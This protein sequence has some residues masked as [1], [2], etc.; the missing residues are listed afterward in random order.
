[1]TIAKEIEKLIERLD[2]VAV[3]DDCI[4]DK[5]DLSATAQANVATRA[6]GGEPGFERQR[7]DCGLCGATKTV[8]RRRAR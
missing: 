2:G 1:M 7:A 8:I 6:L 4:T 3:C 5:L